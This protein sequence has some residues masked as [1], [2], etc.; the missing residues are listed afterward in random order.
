MPTTKSHNEQQED[1]LL[2]EWTEFDRGFRRSSKCNLWRE[3]Q[4]LTLSVFRRTNGR[5]AWCIAEQGD[6][7]KYSPTSFDSEE[8]ALYDLGY[9]FFVF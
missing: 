6:E 9:R 4:G 8:D 3:Y 7:R 2:R 1:A 5:Y